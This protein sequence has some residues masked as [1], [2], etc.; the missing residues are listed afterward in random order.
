MAGDILLENAVDASIVAFWRESDNDLRAR[1]RLIASSS[2]E[3]E[4]ARS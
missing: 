3:L 1:L 4:K 2:E